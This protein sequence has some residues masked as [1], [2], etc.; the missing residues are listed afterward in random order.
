MMRAVLF[1]LWLTAAGAVTAAEGGNYAVVGATVHTLGSAEPLEDAVVLVADGRIEAVGEGLAVPA[2]YERIDAS[3][4]ARG[5]AA[6]T[7][8]LWLDMLIS[9]RSMSRKNAIRVSMSYLSHLFP[10]H[11][12]PVSEERQA[13]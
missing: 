11:F 9:P 1:G 13:S 3:T 8:G 7:E 6:I 2:G 12:E 4:A 10:K 5:L